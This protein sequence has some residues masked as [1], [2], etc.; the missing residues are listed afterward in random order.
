MHNNFI[1]EAQ[2]FAIQRFI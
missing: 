1:R 2:Q